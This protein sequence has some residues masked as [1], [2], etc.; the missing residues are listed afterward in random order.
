MFDYFRVGE[1]F[2]NYLCIFLTSGGKIRVTANSVLD[3]VGWLSMSGDINDSVRRQC[4][5]DNIG[6][7]SYTHLDVYKRQGYWSSASTAYAILLAAT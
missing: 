3:I 5:I 1:D 2:G 6:P 4:Q 7:V